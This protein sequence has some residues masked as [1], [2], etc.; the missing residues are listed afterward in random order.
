MGASRAFAR[1]VL[2]LA[3]VAGLSGCGWLGEDED[4]PLPGERIAV[5]LVDQD[6]EPDPRLADLEVRLPAPYVNPDWTQAGGSSSHALHHLALGDVPTRVWSADIGS[7]S[8]GRRRLL[9]Q[10]IVADGRVFTMDL[11]FE[12]RAFDLQTG[13]QLWSYEAEPPRRDSEAFGGGLA[14]GNGK[15]FIG[16]GFAAMIAVRPETGEEVWRVALPAP[17]RGAPSIALG[18][19]LAITVDNQTTAIDAETGE[20]QWTHTGFAETAGLLGGAS[21]AIL[22]GVAVVAYSSGEVAALRLNNGRAVWSDNLTAVRRVDAVSALADIRAL[23]VIDRDVVYAISHAGRMVALDLRVG[24]RLWDRSIGGLH[25]PWIAGEF[26]FVLTNDQQVAAVTRRGGRVKWIAQLRQWQDE[27]DRTDPISWAGP[28]LAGDRLIL[29]GSTGEIVT[30]SP[31]TGE[32]LGRVDAGGSV[33][34]APIVVNGTLLVLTDSG[35]LQ[36]WR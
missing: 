3:L 13:R 1:T 12:V 27:E 28:V 16:T 8:S 34:L 33:Y 19:V 32:I 21:P 35:T 23:P 7:G 10:P 4:P 30:M 5:M 26:V 31:Y 18:Y 20:R 25:M 24:A 9:T 36:A 15:L 11:D 22:S 17:M 6:L 29:A 14:Y 2:G